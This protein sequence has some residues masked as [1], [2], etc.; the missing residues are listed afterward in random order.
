[1]QSSSIC[2]LCLTEVEYGDFLKAPERAK[3]ESLFSEVIRVDSLSF[4]DAD[5][6]F[7]WLEQVKPKILVTCWKTPTLPA[8]PSHPGLS[9]LKYLCHLGGSVRKLVPRTLIES[10]L[11]VSNWGSCISRVVAECGLLLILTEM[12]RSALWSMRMHRE[13]A[14]K[15]DSLDTQSLYERK[16]GLHGFGA[17]SRCLVDL[18]KPFNVSISAYSPSVPDDLFASYGV[19]RS[20]SLEDLFSQNDIIVEL[21]ALTPKNHHIVDE[22]LLRMIPKNG[23]FVNIGR[24]AVVDEAALARIAAEGSLRVALDVYESEPLPM[25]SPLRAVDSITLL[26][27][28]GGP[29]VDQRCTAGAYGVDNLERYV[30]QKELVS[31]VD[32][33]SYDHST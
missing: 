9:E 23:V 29:T 14:W 26:P 12:R 19:T 31:T 20:E 4:A 17:I 10:G 28:L 6:W 24:G 7:D 8:D 22:R 30:Q 11:V 27:H 33:W 18:L 1:M 2:Y 15:D 32:L 13:G 25:D 16:V 5:A 3:L 21:A